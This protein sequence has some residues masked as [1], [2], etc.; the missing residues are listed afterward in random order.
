M[1]R[2]AEREGLDHLAPVQ[3]FGELAGTRV[4][5]TGAD[6]QLGRTLVHREHRT[7]PPALGQRHCDDGGEQ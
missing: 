3:G 5:A 2:T 7:E 1:G 4:N 6:R